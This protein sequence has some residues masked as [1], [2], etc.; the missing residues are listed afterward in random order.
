MLPENSEDGARRRMK[1]GHLRLAV[2]LRFSLLR[3]LSCRVLFNSRITI[4]ISRVPGYSAAPVMIRY[5][6][7]DA[8]GC[9]KSERRR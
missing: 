9:G 5:L 6:G 4:T 2:A 8:K 7:P 1:L 3:P